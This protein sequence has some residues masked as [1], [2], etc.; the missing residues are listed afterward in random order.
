MEY[1]CIGKIINTH[2]I[3]GEVKIQSYSD[4][5]DLRYRRGNT[6]YIKKENTYRLDIGGSRD[7][8]AL[9]K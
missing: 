5:D 6:V 9:Q 4:F 3:R 1:I 2:G 8:G 7:N